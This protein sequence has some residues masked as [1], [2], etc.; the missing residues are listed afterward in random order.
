MQQSVLVF[1]QERHSRLVPY[2]CQYVNYTAKLKFTAATAQKIG[3]DEPLPIF[4]N[5]NLLL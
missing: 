5:I 1:I 2:V 4:L 3:W